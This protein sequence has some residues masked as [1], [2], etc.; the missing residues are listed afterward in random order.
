MNPR[1]CGQTI[2]ATPIP[3]SRR[4]SGRAALHRGASTWRTQPSQSVRPQ[5]PACSTPAPLRLWRATSS[6]CWATRHRHPASARRRS[7][8]RMPAMSIR[9]RSR[10]ASMRRSRTCASAFVAW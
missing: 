4:P 6:K 5:L 9:A 8:P 7:L 1:C 10:P 2:T 3:W